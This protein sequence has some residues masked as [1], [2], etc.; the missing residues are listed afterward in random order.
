MGGRKEGGRGG[1]AKKQSE[2]EKKSQGREKSEEYDAKE[3][4]SC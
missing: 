1:T 2:T 3:K 4:R